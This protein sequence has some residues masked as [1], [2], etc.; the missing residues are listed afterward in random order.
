MLHYL[1]TTYYE[2]SLGYG[3]AACALEE[4]S[5][6]SKT[7]RVLGVVKTPN[8]TSA[9]Y[10]RMSH[11]ILGEQLFLLTVVKSGVMLGG[12]FTIIFH[13]FNYIAF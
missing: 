3:G 13:L 4:F 12:S 11:G 2:N 1:K 9:F 5:A 7:S 6:R 8:Q 10:K